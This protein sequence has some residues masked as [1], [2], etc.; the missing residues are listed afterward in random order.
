[1]RFLQETKRQIKFKS[2]TQQEL[3]LAFAET[4]RTC[5]WHVSQQPVAVPAIVSHGPHTSP[6]PPIQSWTGNLASGGT[7]LFP[8]L[9]RDLDPCDPPWVTDSGLCVSSQAP[10]LLTQNDCH[11]LDNCR[12]VVAEDHGSQNMQTAGLP[13]MLRELL[14]GQEKAFLQSA[15]HL[16]I[17]GT[18]IS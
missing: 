4:W 11:E 9:Q 8:D 15:F 3:A 17:C 2:I 6:T 13:I 7:A 16:H 18:V 5:A 14:F 10:I 1:M 12:A